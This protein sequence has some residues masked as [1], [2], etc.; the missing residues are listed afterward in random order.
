[1]TNDGARSKRPSIV[2]AS[3]AATLIAVVLVIAA[4][5]GPGSVW[6]V[7]ETAE[8][9]PN[10]QEIEVQERTAADDGDENST[11]WP[12]IVGPAAT[13]VAMLLLLVGGVGGLVAAGELRSWRPR[14]R[15]SGWIRTP[16]DIDPELAAEQRP[17]VID[18][19]AAFDLLRSGRARNAIVACWMQLEFDAAHAGVPRRAAETTAE[20]VERVVASSSI[21]RRPIAALSELYREARFSTRSITDEHRSNAVD[22]LRQVLESL[23]T[24]LDTSPGRE[25]ARR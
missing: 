17:V 16:A 23:D 4:T 11:R 18:A 25:T 22:L 9:T 1:M 7:P 5:A 20:Y 19:D 13:V 15:R 8:Q 21:D 10:A 14:L 2:L 24:S 12:S 6:I 3:V